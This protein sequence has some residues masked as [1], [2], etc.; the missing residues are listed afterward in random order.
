MPLPLKFD[1]PYRPNPWCAFSFLIIY[2]TVL[3]LCCYFNFFFQLGYYEDPLIK[4]LK[5]INLY[6]N[7]PERE[8]EV[9]LS[10]ELLRCAER[11]PQVL[12]ISYCIFFLKAKN[13]LLYKLILTVFG[14]QLAL[15]CIYYVSK[16]KNIL[17]DSQM[18]C[19]SGTS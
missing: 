1:L 8:R 16:V 12:T 15:H 11:L 4:Y 17:S 5:K 14:L 7:L 10:T 13:D 19:R 2:S 6:E 9:V 18:W 3:V